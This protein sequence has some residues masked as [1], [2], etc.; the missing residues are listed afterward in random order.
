MSDALRERVAAMAKRER[1]QIALTP[2]HSGLLARSPVV[3]YQHGYLWIGNDDPKDMR[4][5]GYLDEAKTLRL[6][7]AIVARAARRGG[8]DVR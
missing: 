5:Y 8:S 6:A 1:N 2:G 7:K 4:C 3:S